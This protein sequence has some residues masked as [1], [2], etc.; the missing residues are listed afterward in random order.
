MVRITDGILMENKEEERFEGLEN[1]RVQ[2]LR[3]LI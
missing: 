2:L 3:I 1:K